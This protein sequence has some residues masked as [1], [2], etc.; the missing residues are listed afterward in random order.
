MPQPLQ[1][2]ASAVGDLSGATHRQTADR[3][4][5]VSSGTSGSSEHPS[6]EL[7][8][9]TARTVERALQALWD[10]GVLVP[11]VAWAATNSGEEQHRLFGDPSRIDTDLDH[12][13]QL[14]RAYVDAF[15]C[16]RVERYVW[17]YDGY[18]GQSHHE[19]V[20]VEVAERGHTH[21]WLLAARYRLSKRG[22]ALLD[23][24]LVEL[25]T[26]RTPFTT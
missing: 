4:S 19:A 13:L 18:A 8:T 3:D 12:G 2:L 1:R 7:Q 6:A 25:A 16:E 14:A 5:S 10:G 9:L 15:N 20:V 21:G 24:D 17:V 22:I 26:I 11:V 23:R